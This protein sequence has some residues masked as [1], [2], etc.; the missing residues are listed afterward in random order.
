MKWQASWTQEGEYI[1]HHLLLHIPN[2]NP[3]IMHNLKIICHVVIGHNIP[4]PFKMNLYIYIY[5][6]M[7][8]DLLT[9]YFLPLVGENST[10]NFEVCWMIRILFLKKEK[11]KKKK[12][13]RK[14]EKKKENDK[15]FDIGYLDQFFNHLCEHLKQKSRTSHIL[16]LIRNDKL[17]VW[18]QSRLIHNHKI[19]WLYPFHFVDPLISK[20]KFHSKCILQ[21]V[22][23]MNC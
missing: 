8:I 9:L 19:S 21:N 7:E 2:L 11:R 13:K 5:I 15:N 1:Y 16:E 20:F 6:Y 3:S 23:L 4:F 12:K 10:S 17:N 14:K 18:N 22:K